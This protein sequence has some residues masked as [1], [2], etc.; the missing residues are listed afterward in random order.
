METTPTEHSSI[1]GHD[2]EEDESDAFLLGNE[3]S[4]VRELEHELVQIDEE[5]RQLAQTPT[6]KKKGFRPKRSSTLSDISDLANEV[7]KL[8][9]YETSLFRQL[10]DLRL[11]ER[12]SLESQQS[13]DEIIQMN[14]ETE[15]KNKEEMMMHQNNPV[16]FRNSMMAK[17]QSNLSD[18]SDVS[19]EMDKLEST[20]MSSFRN[21]SN[22]GSVRERSLSDSSDLPNEMVDAL[23]NFQKSWSTTEDSS[24]LETEEG[25]L[26]TQLDEAEEKNKQPIDRPPVG[27]PEKDKSVANNEELEARKDEMGLQKMKT[28]EE[29]R[30]QIPCHELQTE[31]QISRMSSMSIE[32]SSHARLTS[33]TRM[34]KQ[35]DDMETVTLSVH[36][37]SS[38]A[39]QF[40]IL[41]ANAKS[42]RN[43]ANLDSNDLADIKAL[44]YDIF[45]LWQANGG[46]ET[47]RHIRGLQSA[48]LEDG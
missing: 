40:V 14:D 39:L 44:K 34:I 42:K 30:N 10:S 16:V 25:K 6:I 15:N 35:D 1:T 9:G 24:D 31:K 4:T 12:K 20:E 45:N 47:E 27:G 28:Q 41:D 37:K 32:S 19:N 17:R 7:D 18:I 33:G 3:F 46:R 21:S 5:M 22:F 23:E 29:T 38:A 2:D 48:I 8:Q 13:G 11:V 26:K 43:V 36:K